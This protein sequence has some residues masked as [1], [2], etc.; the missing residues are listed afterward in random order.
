MAKCATIEKGDVELEGIDGPVFRRVYE[1]HQRG[2]AHFYNNR[3]GGKATVYPEQRKMFVNGEER[4]FN[5]DATMHAALVKVM[6]IDTTD[7]QE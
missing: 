1:S 7:D 2:V 3:K 6:Q 5:K 4:R